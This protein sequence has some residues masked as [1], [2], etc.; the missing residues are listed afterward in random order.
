MRGL[1]NATSA[2]TTMWSL[3]CAY[4]PRASSRCARGGAN[5]HRP[6]LMSFGPSAKTPPRHLGPA[7]R[8]GWAADAAEQQIRVEP[9]QTSTS[10]DLSP[11]A[12]PITGGWFRS[13][14]S[15]DGSPPKSPDAR[16]DSPFSLGGLAA[17]AGDALRADNEALFRQGLFN[18]VGNA[19]LLLLV[20]LLFAV[21]SLLSQ[22]RAPILW[23]VLVSLALRDVKVALVRFWTVQLTRHTLAGVALAPARAAAAAARRASALAAR[24]VVAAVAKKRSSDASAA[25]TDEPRVT[26]DGSAKRDAPPSERRTMLRASAGGERRNTYA[27]GANGGTSAPPTHTIH[28]DGSRGGPPPDARDASTFHF[29]WLFYLGCATET[30]ALA[31][32]DWNLTRSV[33]ALGAVLCVAA[34]A[35]TGAVV[36]ADVYVFKRAFAFASPAAFGASAAAEGRRGGRGSAT[37]ATAATA[38]PERRDGDVD[39]VGAARGGPA[40]ATDATDGRADAVTRTIF[41]RATRL[42]LR[43]D[44]AIRRLVL[45]NLHALVAT[46][47][48]VGGIAL[49]AAVA[50]FFAVN[51]ARESAEAVAAAREAVLEGSRGGAGLGGL[52]RRIRDS[53][54]A[55]GAWQ[56]AW[57][58]AVETHWPRVLEYTRARV[59]EA[60][61]EANATEVWEAMRHVYASA[62]EA[63]EASAADLPGDARAS[64][65]GWSSTARRAGKLLGDG[66]FV[67]AATAARDVFET[68]HADASARS[69]LR[70]LLRVGG[71]VADALRA[72]AST[73]LAGSSKGVGALCSLAFSLFASAFGVAGATATFLLKCVVFFTALFHVLASEADPATRL[74]ELIPLNDRVKATA[75]KAVTEGA[76]GVFVSCLKLALFHA[77]FTWVTFRAFGARFVYTSTLVSGATAIL[78][79]LASWSVSLPAAFSMAAKGRAARGAALVVAHW[80]ALVFVDIDIYQTEIRVVHPYVV[81]LSVVGGMCAFPPAPQGAVLGPLLVTALATGHALYQE[82]VRTP[83]KAGDARSDRKAKREP[84]SVARRRSEGN[85]A[86]RTG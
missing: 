66:D 3:K 49:A 80:V 12:S 10:D 51:V 74:A 85:A 25:S 39:D 83:P 19:I 8:R 29:R 6:R 63:A 42:Y 48:I 18:A 32:R 41:S 40:P 45:A 68:V 20:G 86:R 24:T 82:L 65:G 50:A 56:S 76:R 9:R 14:L 38:A 37:A 64:A 59:E 7:P 11:P 31:A 52:T 73:L 33:V 2:K 46:G 17:R 35:T 71:G 58:S 72:R 26:A 62:R 28:D 77:A 1:V 15:G 78:P 54:D 36:A 13:R 60:F 47:L 43:L 4:T 67:G 34:F 30:Y 23:A 16:A 84:S 81:G 5:A 70:V 61:P 22:Y 75:V 44:L 69:P 27:S 53:R 55:D 21:S 57:S 79:L